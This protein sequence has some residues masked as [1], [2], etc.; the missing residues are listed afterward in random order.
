MEHMKFKDYEYFQPKF[1]EDKKLLLS[2]I[3]NIKTSITLTKTLENIHAFNVTRGNIQTLFAIANIRYTS[4]TSNSYYREEN[5]FWNEHLPLYESIFFE[6]ELSILNS[7]FKDKIKQQFGKQYFT[8]LELNQQSFSN[9]ILSDIQEENNLISSYVNLLASAK[10][11]YNKNIYNLSEISYFNFSN[12]RKIRKD[13]NEAKYNFFRESEYEID[14]IFDN[15]VKIRDKMAKKLGYENYVQLGYIKMKRNGYSI[16]DIRKFRENIAKYVVP[17]AGELYEKQKKRFSLETLNYYDENMEFPQNNLSI[18]FNYVD[19]LEKFEEIFNEMSPQTSSLFNFLKKRELLDLK[20]RKNKALGG[21]CTYIW[22]HG[23][24][25]IFANFNN[26]YNDIRTFTHEIGHALHSYLS[27]WI[28]I[29]GYRCTFECAELHSMSMELFVF[30]WIDK[31]FEKN[32][33]KYKFAILT[34]AIKFIPYAAA[35]DEFQEK[36]YE[37]SNL[38]PKDRKKLWQLVEKKYLP[39]RNYS[40]SDFLEAG[41]WW[42][43]QAHIFKTPFYYIDYALAEVSALQFVSKIEA[44][45]TKA[46]N[47]YLGICNVGGLYS[48]LELLQKANLKSP[49]EENTLQLLVNEIKEKLNALESSI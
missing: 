41:N 47:D 29:P 18:N 16:Y 7:P 5:R 48:F 40:E 3:E 15:L 23:A 17:L 28:D 42:V 26:T 21:Y 4:D 44:N 35:I 22:N 10:I 9:E 1:E 13:S 12:D 39:H 8:I 34:S 38:T 37:N 14:T 36:V 27:K 43:Q 25:F 32:I 6:F 31:I 46:L 30:P 24:P 20:T 49:F 11:T 19:L 33:N 2:L 45:H